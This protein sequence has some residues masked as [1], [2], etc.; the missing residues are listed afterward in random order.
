MNR[1]SFKSLFSLALAVMLIT[2]CGSQ[3]ISSPPEPDA[4]IEPSPTQLPAAIPTETPN[5]LGEVK[6]YRDA[7]AGFALDYP[8]VWF[9]EDN[10]AQDAAGS[11]AYT[12]SL[13]SWDRV[14]YTPT[15]KDLNTLPNG[16]TKIDITVFNRGPGT[17]E[18]AV[19]QYKSQDSVSPVTFLKEEDW[20]LNSGEKA[21]YLES[22]GMFGVVATVIMLV[23]GKVIYVSGYGNLTPFKAIAL[24]LRAE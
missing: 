11:A 20:T 5:P 17:L 10:A 22:E 1:T 13:F 2:A 4:V 14:S 23:E 12:V 8:A 15:P 19:N 3:T 21:A 18:E 24:T 6:V 16:A 7:N 9:I